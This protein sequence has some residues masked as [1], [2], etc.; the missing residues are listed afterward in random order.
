ME[1]SLRYLQQRQAQIASNVREVNTPLNRCVST[2][3]VAASSGVGVLMGALTSWL[4]FF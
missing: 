2:P 1:M 3:L 4:I